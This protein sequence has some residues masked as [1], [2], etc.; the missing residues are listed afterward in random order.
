MMPLV[1]GFD[2]FA[3]IVNGIAFHM[4]LL[5]G[6]KGVHSVCHRIGA[7]PKVRMM[8]GEK[9]EGGRGKSSGQESQGGEE[10]GETGRGE[11]QADRRRQPI[12]GA[13]RGCRRRSRG[14]GLGGA[15]SR[16]WGSPRTEQLCREHC[17]SPLAASHKLSSLSPV[18]AS[19][20]R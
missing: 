2:S 20:P 8:E 14:A 4:T 1:Q 15:R 10:G 12:R 3:I 16:V 9:K 19:Q 18:R 7:A 17:E 13:L 11:D 5:R 6:L